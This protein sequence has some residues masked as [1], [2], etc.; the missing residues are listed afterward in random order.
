MQKSPLIDSDLTEH[1]IRSIHEEKTSISLNQVE[2]KTTLD[3]VS[4]TS[5]SSHSQW[6][7]VTGSNGAF[8]DTDIELDAGSVIKDTFQIVAKLGEGGMGT[9]FKAVNLVWREAEARN[10]YV[11]LKIL[12]PEL[13]ANR[14][15]FQSLHREFERSKKLA[16]CENIVEVYD[17][18]RARPHVYMAMEFLEG[19][20]LADYILDIGVSNI[21]Q[22]WFIIEGIGNALA[23]AHERDI[24]HRDIKPGNIM[25][26]HNNEVKVLDFGIASKINENENDKT[27]V[28]GHNL[29]ALTVPYASPEMLRANPLD[30]DARD[31]IYAFACVIYEVLTGKKFYTQIVN[32]VGDKLPRGRDKKEWIA[33]HGKEFYEQILK[34]SIPELNARQMMALRKAL[35]YDREQR[36][37]NIKELLKNLSLIESSVE[38]PWVRHLAIASVVLIVGGLVW[39]FLATR[40]PPP[41]VLPMNRVP[42]HKDNEI[43]KKLKAKVDADAKAKEPVELKVQADAETKAKVVAELKLQAEID[44]KAKEDKAARDLQSVELSYQGVS[45]DGVIQLQTPQS[46]Y[47][48]G[49]NGDPFYVSFKLTEPRYIRLIQYDTKKPKELIP[50]GLQRDVLFDAD[51]EYDYPPKEYVKYAPKGELIR[52]N[53]INKYGFRLKTSDVCHCVMTLVASK[54]PFPKKIKPVNKDGTI[55]KEITSGDYSWVQ[56]QYT[57]E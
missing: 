28:S 14:D 16:G 36:T 12:K 48:T 25:I 38:F 1:S 11:A 56:V 52:I 43:K 10:P 4:P 26:T 45:S 27:K 55:S 21:R 33:S 20:T 30:P 39:W 2:I 34:V 19:E 13:S 24:V 29:G 54:S 42:E 51:K 15:L 35:A 57:L 8:S 22:A 44:A 3:P 7:N 5:T 50:N 17:F 6:S 18:S 31:D 47:K 49:T 53:N 32:A 46:S 37:D 41:K 40:D 23:Y 9:V